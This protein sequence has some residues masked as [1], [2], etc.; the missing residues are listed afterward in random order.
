MICRSTSVI[1]RFVFW[2]FQKYRTNIS[3]WSSQSINSGHKDLMSRIETLCPELPRT[4]LA[5]KTK[6]PGARSIRDLFCCKDTDMYPW[7][8]TRLARSTRAVV[9]PGMRLQLQSNSGHKD[10]MSRMCRWRRA[11]IFQKGWSTHRETLFFVCV[12]VSACQQTT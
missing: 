11:V 10:L 8:Q 1:R 7:K 9:P 5:T 12:E 2:N 4:G 3:G 6:E